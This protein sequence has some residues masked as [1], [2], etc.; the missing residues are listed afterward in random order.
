M[1]IIDRNHPALV[2][3]QKR[4]PLTKKGSSKTTY[5]V[6]LNLKD[7]HVHFKAGDSLG[8]YS[9]NDPL[10]VQQLLNALHLQGNETFLHEASKEILQVRTFF[11][12]KANLFRLTSSFLK[13]YAQVSGPHQP[14]LGV[15]LHPDNK[16]QLQDYL[17]AHDPLAFLKKFA[18]IKVPLNTLCNLFAPLLPRFYSV[19]SSLKKQNE[20]VDLVVALLS[21]TQSGEKRYGV[22]SHFLCH[23]AK[24]NE[25]PI[26]IY[27]QPAHRFGLPDDHN[28]PLIMVGPGTGVAPHRAFLQERVHHGSKGKN[29]LFFGER[30]REFDFFYED[31][32][33]DLVSKNHLRLDLAFSRDQAE[34]LYVQHKMYENRAD[35]WNWLQDGAHFYVCGD[36]TNMAKDVDAMLHKII[37]SEGNMSP[38]E[39]KAYVK[40]LRQTRRY[41]ADI[42]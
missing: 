34:K 21:F 38:D 15:L 37:A 28:V 6:T 26:P 24:E 40:Q 10:L 16:L 11:T 3:I 13:L 7:S 14:D 32:W 31:F 42:Y 23:L 5:H 9:Q 4:F 39:V 36:A 27:V 17:G 25:T 20:S 29:W 33:T 8:I 19:A 41:L 1:S 35:I 30:H 22:A 2:T 18:A 12:H